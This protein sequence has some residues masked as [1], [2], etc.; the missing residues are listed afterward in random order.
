MNLSNA[1][2][3]KVVL[4]TGAGSGMGLA[5]AKAFADAGASLVLADRNEQAVSDAA[6]DIIACNGKAIAVGCDIADEAQVAATIQSTLSAFGRLDVAFNN[7]G[8]NRSRTVDMTEVTEDEWNR[9]MSVNLRGTWYCMKHELLQ[10]V[11][12]GEGVIVNCS[13]AAG[14]RGQAGSSAYVASKHGIIGL[15]KTAAIEYAGRGI[16]V[17]AVCPGPIDTPMMD[18]VNNGDRKALLAKI[19]DTRFGRLGTPDEIA[20]TVLWLAGPGAGFVTGQAIA[21]DGG[22]S[23]G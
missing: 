18:Q 7:A 22:I 17:N 2:Q 8:V 3:D 16:R 21:V 12:Q 11:K 4:V 10:M 6:A 13:S 5:T 15:T 20:G 23:A 14:L 1:F 9:I 19:K